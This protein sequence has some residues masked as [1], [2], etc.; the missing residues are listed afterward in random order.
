MEQDQSLDGIISQ[1]HMLMKTTKK[2]L[3]E[4]PEDTLLRVGFYET[5]PGYKV[6]IDK[7]YTDAEWNKMYPYF[8]DVFNL[9]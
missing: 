6:K 4:L 8:K 3:A 9:A 2:K 7:F 1:A 5:I